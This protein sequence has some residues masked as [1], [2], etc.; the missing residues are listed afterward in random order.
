MHVVSALYPCDTESMNQSEVACL[1]RKTQ[2][3]EGI[4]PMV[5][6]RVRSGSNVRL[7]NGCKSKKKS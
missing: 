3:V 7:R 6:R 2:Q 5:V 1:E 4:C